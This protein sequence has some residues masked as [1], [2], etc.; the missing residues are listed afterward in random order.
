[1]RGIRLLN[2]FA[3]LAIIAGALVAVSPA[4]AD[5]DSS[6]KTILPDSGKQA[7]TR[8]AAEIRKKSPNGLR[9][10]EESG[11]N[12]VV[13]IPPAQLLLDEMRKQH[14]AGKLDDKSLRA[15]EQQVK[16]MPQKKRFESS[17]LRVGTGFEPSTTLP[18]PYGMKTQ[19]GGT[20]NLSERFMNKFEVITEYDLHRVLRNASI[21]LTNFDGGIERDNIKNHQNRLGQFF[22]SKASSELG[23]GGPDRVR[24]ILL[25]TASF[26]ILDQSF[27]SDRG[28]PLPVED[29]YVAALIIGTKF[30]LF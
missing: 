30:R 8:C 1:M 9:Y 6:G 19:Y 16:A 29:L 21:I 23:L 20:L 10:L 28:A 26:M 27:L 14:A 5:Q 4:I 24:D 3:L 12:L 11:L 2:E 18:R 25:L 15:F 17:H 13:V 22:Q 7:I